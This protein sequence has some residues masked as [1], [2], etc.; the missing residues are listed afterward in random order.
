[1]FIKHPFFAG[2]LLIFLLFVG[3]PVRAQ[4]PSAAVP[5]PPV[6]DKKA[7]QSI[8]GNFLSG[9][10]ALT[11][12]DTA[13]ARRYLEQA[14]KDDPGNVEFRGRLLLLQIND[15][16]IPEAVETA[17]E[18]KHKD[19]HELIVDLLLAV[20]KTHDH[21]YAGALE[22]LSTTKIPQFN[23]IWLPLIRQWL[24]HQ[25]GNTPKVVS[26]NLLFPDRKNLP[27]FLTYHIGLLN[28]FSGHTDEAAKNYAASVKDLNRAPF[29]AM[30]AYIQNRARSDD[31]KT[32]GT[33]AARLKQN[34]PDTYA[35][36]AARY[37]YLE[38][39]D[40][41][42]A[43]PAELL[44][45]NPKEGFAEVLFTMASLLYA[46]D[47][48]QDV[49]LYLRMAIY[50][51]PDFPTAQLMLANIF[52]HQQQTYEALELYRQIAPDSHLY[53]PAQVRRAYLLD[54]TKRSDEAL[55]LLDTIAK[56]APDSLEVII[57]RGDI[58]RTQRK[59][60]EAIVQYTDAISKMPAGDA[61]H[62]GAYFARGAC[63]ERTGDI[64]HAETDLKH[65][66]KL[67]PHQA[68]VLNYLGYMWLTSGE[69]K[70]KAFD[71]IERAYTLAPGEAHIVDSYG[72][73]HYSTGKLDK[74]IQL[75]EEAATMDPTE[76]TVNDHL[77]DAYFHKGRKTEADY[78]WQRALDQS[79]D[80]EQQTTLKLKLKEG[81]KAYPFAKDTPAVV[82]EPIPESKELIYE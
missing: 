41:P 73:A 46:V 67:A 3:A 33:F 29:R 26:M 50:L 48:T 56:L 31:R 52:E 15:G 76:P 38:H 47:S 72:W 65:A 24:S 12:G 23:A 17:K 55:A 5:I 35:L 7:S 75:L 30:Q 70:D 37:P 82:T 63:Y 44:A 13:T 11:Q 53:I 39:L 42:E 28:E 43:L 16:D 71:L 8:S 62:W 19:G 79:T 60:P 22:A 14:V 51:R 4:T 64:A 66:L 57:A 74:A 21:K 68:E 25:G 18:L 40:S 2:F 61:T 27:N 32:L 58:L 9:Y 34:R 45:S 36:L 1:M 69:K 77:G 80:P 10:Y 59:Y 54:G 78:Q 81:I 6:A 49:V 20:D